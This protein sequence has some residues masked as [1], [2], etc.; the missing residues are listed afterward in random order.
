[1]TAE[2]CDRRE[3]VEVTARSGLLSSTVAVQTGVGGASC[4][5]LIKAPPGRT[6]RFDLLDYSPGSLDGPCEAYAII[7]ETVETGAHTVC[8][9]HDRVYTST[10]NLVEVRLLTS[11][12]DR[13]FLLNYTSE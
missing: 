6:I 1:M 5:W 10:S 7:K 11:G 2:P 13:T 3:A 4:P 12:S 8:R 9:G